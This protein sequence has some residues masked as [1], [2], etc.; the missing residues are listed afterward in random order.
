MFP[1]YLLKIEY[2]PYFPYYRTNGLSQLNYYSN[3]SHQCLPEIAFILRTL[4]RS[5]LSS[6]L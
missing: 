3:L 4:Y 1:L 6:V 5:S 2:Y